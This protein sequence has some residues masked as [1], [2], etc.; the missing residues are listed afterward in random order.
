MTL[1]PSSNVKWDNL[2]K[3]CN[4]KWGENS[5]NILFSVSQ[6]LDDTMMIWFT[7]QNEVLQNKCQDEKIKLKK[8][9]VLKKYLKQ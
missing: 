1:K 3:K 5:M 4:G 2:P 7:K 6:K 9:F 8:K